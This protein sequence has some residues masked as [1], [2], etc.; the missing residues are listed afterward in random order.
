MEEAEN[1]AI[2]YGVMVYEDHISCTYR[3][4]QKSNVKL[5]MNRKRVGNLSLAANAV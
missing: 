3:D 1:P 5:F 2:V 4:K